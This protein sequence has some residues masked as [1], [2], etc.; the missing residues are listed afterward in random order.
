MLI[1]KPN[2]HFAGILSVLS[3]IT[4]V[5]CSTSPSSEGLGMTKLS[6]AKPATL[7]SCTALPAN[8]KF[9]KTLLVSAE[10]VAAGKIGAGAQATAY[11]APEHCLVKGKMHERK[12]INDQ[13]FAI[14]FEMR[15]PKD[16]NGRFY[17]QI[18][19]AHV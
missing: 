17:H 4:L 16:W 12:G 10:T 2:R 11:N 3:A 8:F 13:D 9:E 14:A 7:S 15:L 1:F 6:E 19:R 5:A 18:G